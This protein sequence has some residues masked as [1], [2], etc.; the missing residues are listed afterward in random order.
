MVTG[1]DAGRPAGG[2]LEQEARRHAGDSGSPFTVSRIYHGGSALEAGAV[3]MPL[4]Q[5]QQLSSLQ[6]KVSTIH[7]R[8]RPDRRGIA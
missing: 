1:G 4:D 8:L 6:G 3:I 2:K 7:V 5:L